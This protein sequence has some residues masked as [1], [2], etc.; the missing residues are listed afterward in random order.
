M[1]IKLCKMDKYNLYF[2]DP[3]EKYLALKIEF[4]HKT[5]LYFGWKNIF[6][7]EMVYTLPQNP[8]VT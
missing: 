1:I 4:F 8:L 7:P 6:L 5:N 3:G 2:K